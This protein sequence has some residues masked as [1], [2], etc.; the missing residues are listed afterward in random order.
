MFNGRSF[1]MKL[2]QWF[3]WIGFYLASHT[4]VYA[5]SNHLDSISFH[6]ASQHR[7]QI[8]LTF[9]QPLSKQQQWTSF[10][11]QKKSQIS[12]RFARHKK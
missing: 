5:A 1:N 6:S 11:Y 10:C 7:F 9:K 3:C 8:T 12:V 4:M 2:I